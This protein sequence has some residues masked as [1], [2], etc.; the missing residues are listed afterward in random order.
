MFLLAAVSLL[1]AQQPATSSLVSLIG[2]GAVER[3][4]GSTLLVVW[5]CLPWVRAVSCPCTGYLEYLFQNKQ[6]LGSI[7]QAVPCISAGKGRK[8]EN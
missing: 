3:N 6:E 8:K 5:A 7:S 1:V 2:G 4:S